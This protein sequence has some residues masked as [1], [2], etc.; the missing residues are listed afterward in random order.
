MTSNIPEIKKLI[1]CQITNKGELLGAEKTR[2][3][4]NDDVECYNQ[5]L[6]RMIRYENC[7]IHWRHKRLYRN[8][9]E[10]SDDGTH[11]DTIEGKRRY[12]IYRRR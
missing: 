1:I 10:A 5:E 2:D 4:F 12:K 11:L 7:I 8:F 9:E 6:C 3:I